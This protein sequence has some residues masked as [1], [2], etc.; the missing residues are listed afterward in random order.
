[1]TEATVRLSALQAWAK[2]S[3]QSGS[4]IGDAAAY[5]FAAET[6]RPAIDSDMSLAKF[7]MLA[8]EI[9][10]RSGAPFLGWTVGLSFELAALG[11]IGEAIMASTCLRGALQRIVDY[12]SIIQDACDVRL[13]VTGDDASLSY[14]ILDPDIW[15]RRQDALFTLGIFAKIIRMAV[16]PEWRR[17]EVVLEADGQT[18][19]KDAMKALG[20]P[21]ASHGDANCIRFPAAFLNSPFAVDPQRYRPNHARLSRQVALKRRRMPTVLRVKTLIFQEL[22]ERNFNQDTVARTL[23]MSSRTLRRRLAE[24]GVSFQSL[25]DS[26]RMRLAAFEFEIRPDISIAQTALRLG[27]S[28]HSTFTRAFLRW[29]GE[30]PQAYI[31]KTRGRQSACGEGRPDAG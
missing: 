1:M 17:A 6:E 13:E 4:P 19:R 24:E 29:N 20:L 5:A 7:V 14:R 26:C 25:L 18:D 11:E 12:F 8:E 3:E 16:G 28:E 9:A 23:G 10:R 15:P 2:A 31:R 22:N 30:P 27:Y 21:C